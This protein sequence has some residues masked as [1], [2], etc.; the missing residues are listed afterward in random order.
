MAIDTH[1]R[2]YYGKRSTPGIIGGQKK[3]GTN[4]FYG[5]AT[6]I[7]IHKRR[8]FTVGMIPL[9][10]RTKP[11]EIVQALFDRIDRNGLQMRGI[12]LD[13]GFDSGET[14]LLRKRPVKWRPSPGQSAIAFVWPR[15]LAGAGRGRCVW[16]TSVSAHR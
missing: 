9:R 8:R 1:N 15:R 4:Y 13:C 16:P 10:P 12:V 6:A 7:L 11:H 3:Q 5:Y 14:L 2:P